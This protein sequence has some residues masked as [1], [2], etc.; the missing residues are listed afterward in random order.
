M[1]EIIQ[2]GPI[3]FDAKIIHDYYHDTNLDFTIILDT[4]CQLK[5][6]NLS[7]TL[8]FKSSSYQRLIADHHTLL[9]A[10]GKQKSHVLDA[11]GG[12]GKDGFILAHAG[13]K[14]KSCEINPILYLILSQAVE[15]YG[16]DNWEICYGDVLDLLTPYDVIYID[17]MFEIQRS[18]KPKLAMQV[19][20]Q[21]TLDQTFKAWTTL[22]Q[23]CNKRLV[24]KQHTRSP[25]IIGLPK[26]SMQIKGKCNVRYDIYLKS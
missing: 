24:V 3:S 8:D 7:F 26:P 11:F 19:I 2:K 4:P 25:I 22:Y 20:Q 10:I 15:N 1:I 13:H 23:N 9:L 12:L 16:L 21:V 17:P 14:V 6:Q 18:A 5:F